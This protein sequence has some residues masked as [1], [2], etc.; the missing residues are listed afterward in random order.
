MHANSQV[1]KRKISKDIYCAIESVVLQIT[2]RSKYC[3]YKQIMKLILFLS[4]EKLKNLLTHPYSQ[5]SQICQGI[6]ALW[7]ITRKCIV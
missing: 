3:L 2:D 1:S 4:T 7:N 5:F 6:E